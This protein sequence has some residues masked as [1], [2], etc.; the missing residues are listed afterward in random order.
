[1]Y[2]NSRGEFTMIYLTIFVKKICVPRFADI[3]IIIK[4]K[5]QRITTHEQPEQKK[6]TKSAFKWILKR[7]S[8]HTAGVLK[9]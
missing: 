9:A 1:M 5:T 2:A 4:A 6:K 3:A 8:K 7:K